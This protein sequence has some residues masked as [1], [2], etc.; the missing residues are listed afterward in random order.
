MGS[1]GRGGSWFDHGHHPCAKA[2]ASGNTTAVITATANAPRRTVHKA[3]LRLSIANVSRIFAAAVPLA[4]TFTNYEPQRIGGQCSAIAATRMLTG[5]LADRAVG[6]TIPGSP[7]K[8][9]RTM[10]S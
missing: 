10:S 2:A 1:R 5:I 4:R 6:P 7:I 9:L 3:R 8:R